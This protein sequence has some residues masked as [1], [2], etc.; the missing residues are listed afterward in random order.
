MNKILQVREMFKFCPNEFLNKLKTNLTIRFEDNVDVKLSYKEI[1]LLRYILEVYKVIPNVPITSQQLFTNFYV[2]G[3]LTSKTINSSFEVIFRDTVE[4]YV[5]PNNDRTILNTL[6]KEMFEVINTIYNELIFNITD[7]CN[8]INIQ[9]LLDIQ[10]DPNL[11][12]A[13]KQVSVERTAASVNKTY[14]ILDNMLRTK[15]ELK[16]NVVAKNYLAG[17]INPLQVNQML[18]SRGYTT[19]ISSAIYKWPIASSFTLGMSNIYDL[20][21][22]SRS[23]AKALY[24]S[25]QAVSDTEYFARELQLVAMIV[26]RLVDGDCGNHDY[27][28]WYVRPKSDTHKSDLENIVGKY[29]YNPKTKQEEVIKFSDKHLEGTTI[30]LRTALNCKLEDSRCVCTRCFGELSYSIPLHS[31]LGHYCT[32][33]ITRQLT[34]R[35]LS[36]KHL[37][38]TASNNDIVLDD[39]SSKFFIA[40]NNSY[41]FKANLLNKSKIKY[42]LAITQ[43]EAFGIKDLHP[44]ADIYRLNISRVSSIETI[45]LIQEINNKIERYPIIIKDQNKYGNLSYEFLAYIIQKGY[46]LDEAGR[47]LIELNDY[48]SK[49]PFIIMPELEYNYVALTANIKS[50]FRGISIKKGE[51]SKETP[52]SLLQEL[53]NFVNTK[54]S[55]NLSILEVIVYAFTV[56][57]LRNED[58]S[59]SRNSKDR[60]LMKSSGIMSYRSLGAGYGWEHVINK[61]LSPKS[62]NGFNGISHPMDV[63]IKPNEAI[64][65]YYG[66]LKTK[67]HRHL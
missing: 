67:Y 8:S 7:F 51:Y 66:D 33:E 34:Q 35:I 59:L 61:I 3:M 57:S 65:D 42:K 50:L 25:N 58:Y 36:T 32:T 49:K 20:A 41:Y 5:K 29:Y 27:M 19:E 40:K 46:S 64:K 21:V 31:N 30:K 17:T 6:F 43:R 53:F 11:I 52:E 15:P 44:D 37:A 26:E 9:E 4:I 10:M 22:E 24:L 2:S 14:A 39:T 56:S 55:I 63:I 47:Y 28:D 60:Q 1:I 23:G 54:L 13:M 38:A 48:D 18:A 62:F 45:E 12:E 16:T